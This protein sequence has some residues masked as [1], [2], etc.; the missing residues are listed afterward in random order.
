LLLTGGVIGFHSPEATVF[1]Y[2][3]YLLSQSVSDFLFLS[4]IKRIDIAGIDHQDVVKFI[5]DHHKK[6]EFVLSYSF[7]KWAIDQGEDALELFDN[8][9]ETGSD[10]DRIA[11]LALNAVLQPARSENVE[12]LV[13]AMARWS[14]EDLS[15]IEKIACGLN[16][17][18]EK[19]LVLDLLDILFAYLTSRNWV[20]SDRVW[21]VSSRIST[22]VVEDEVILKFMRYRKKALEQAQVAA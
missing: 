19:V 11:R 13:P 14:S 12:E 20:A 2:M 21:A 15:E 10:V 1:K 3:E 9:K 7:L 4:L 8:S 16:D 18:A 5:K 22:A 17:D 6:K